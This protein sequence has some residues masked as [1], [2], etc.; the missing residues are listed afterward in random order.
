VAA[1]KL[2]EREEIS[3]GIAAG[4]DG[5]RSCK[6]AIAAD[7]RGSGAAKSGDG[8]SGNGARDE[9]VFQFSDSYWGEVQLQSTTSNRSHA[10]G[11]NCRFAC[12][13]SALGIERVPPRNASI[14]ASE[15]KRPPSPLALSLAKRVTPAS[16]AVD[17]PASMAVGTPIIS[18]LG[19]AAKH[20]L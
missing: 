2:E 10:V 3:R 6:R 11:F 18:T 17:T 8:G 7:L 19:D 20:G 14:H 13:S 4:H 5:G 15:T 16:M 12:G 1:L 9:K